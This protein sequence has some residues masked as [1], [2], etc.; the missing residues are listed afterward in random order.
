MNVTAKCLQQGAN[1]SYPQEQVGQIR[2]R[3]KTSL[4]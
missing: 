2:H 4:D 3:Q 1:H